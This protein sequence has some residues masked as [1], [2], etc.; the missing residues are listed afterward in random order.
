[1]SHLIWNLI[2]VILI[3]YHNIM[4]KVSNILFIVPIAYPLFLSSLV[5]QWSQQRLQLNTQ[6]AEL[7]SRIHNL[8]RRVASHMMD[9]SSR[10]SSVKEEI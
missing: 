2:K 5:L 3:H 10:S 6:E 9:T 1:M 8:R 4:M 7:L